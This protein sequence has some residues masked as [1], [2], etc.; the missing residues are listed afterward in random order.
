MLKKKKFSLLA[1][2]V[3]DSNGKK[4]GESI[5]VYEDLL[6]IKKDG[7]YYAIPLKHVEVKDNKIRLR[8][9]VQWDKA[10]ELAERW[11]KNV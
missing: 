4:I 2:F 7:N 11:I 5:S 6:I 1:R 9:I 3:V 8:G 10:K